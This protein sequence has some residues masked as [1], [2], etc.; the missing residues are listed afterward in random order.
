LGLAFRVA[1]ADV[2]L[3]PFWDQVRCPTLVLRGADS[4]LLLAET[5][6]D[7]T[8]RGP[9][10]KLVEFPGIGHAPM[11]MEPGQ[12]ISVREFLLGRG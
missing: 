9:K 2:V 8:R 4:D 10:A 7:M 5:A 12:I 3:W 1:P 6:Q 11:L